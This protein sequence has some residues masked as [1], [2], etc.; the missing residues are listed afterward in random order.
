MYK[1]I[2]LLEFKIK[3]DGALTARLGAAVLNKLLARIP[4]R[5]SPYAISPVT[6]R[7]SIAWPRLA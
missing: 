7:R 1:A 5:F 6:E 4:T 2:A 3:A